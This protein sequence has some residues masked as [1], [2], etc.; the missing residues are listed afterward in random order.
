MSAA[1]ASF[2]GQ[3]QRGERA[4]GAGLVSYKTTVLE[5]FGP[6]FSGMGSSAF[7]SVRRLNGA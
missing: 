6:S 5:R 3:A 1:A 4:E 2:A 7:Q